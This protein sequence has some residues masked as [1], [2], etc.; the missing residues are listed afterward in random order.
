M[1]VRAATHLVQGGQEGLEGHGSAQ[2][3][4][5]GEALRGLLLDTLPLPGGARGGDRACGLQRHEA[6]GPGHRLQ[7]HLGG[8]DPAEERG[9]AR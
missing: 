1:V 5:G 7:K 9:Q 8:G 4:L 3:G 6:A 2:E